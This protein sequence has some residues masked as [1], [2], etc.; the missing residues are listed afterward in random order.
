MIGTLVLHE[1]LTRG[2]NQWRAEAGHDDLIYGSD[3]RS[4]CQAI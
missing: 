4:Y 2:P 1:E 3:H